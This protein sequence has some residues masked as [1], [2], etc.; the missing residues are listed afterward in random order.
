MSSEIIQSVNFNDFQLVNLH[1]MFSQ[2]F[3]SLFSGLF[4]DKTN[5]LRVIRYLFLNYWNSEIF[6]FEIVEPC[7]LKINKY[8][9]PKKK[10]D[11]NFE[12][13]K[14]ILNCDPW[15]GYLIIML[16]YGQETMDIICI[17]Y[18]LGWDWCNL[19]NFQMWHNIFSKIFMEL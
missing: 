17:N 4:N 8:L 5:Y 7:F 10:K 3:I 13:R 15:K 19:R 11:Y 12:E 6:N 14:I 16:K 1:V 2:K 9:T 18:D